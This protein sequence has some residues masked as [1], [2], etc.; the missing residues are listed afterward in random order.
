ML[1]AVQAHDHDGYR[2]KYIERYLMVVPAVVPAAPVLTAVI[3]E[4]RDDGLP[5]LTE[6]P[7]A[8]CVTLTAYE[9]YMQA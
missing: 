4:T 2:A 7:W 8:A 1:R 6:P 3:S 5:M 9:V